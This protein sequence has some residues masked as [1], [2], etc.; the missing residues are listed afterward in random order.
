MKTKVKK[1]STLSLEC[2]KLVKSVLLPLVTANVL[3]NE[4]L[5]L[6][7]QRIKLEK[8]IQVIQEEELLTRREVAELLKYSS[9]KSIYNLEKEGLIK[10]APGRGKAKYFK[11]SVDKYAGF[12][13]V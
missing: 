7:I 9:L 11:S 5:L 4:E 8:E 1:L 2:V 13:E 12:K 3:T 10:R 6:I